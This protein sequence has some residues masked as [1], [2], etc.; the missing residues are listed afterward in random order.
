MWKL[1]CVATEVEKLEQDS[2]LPFKDLLKNTNT[3]N[4]SI[5]H[6]R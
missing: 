6:N 4:D 5:I 1:W 3:N 2:N